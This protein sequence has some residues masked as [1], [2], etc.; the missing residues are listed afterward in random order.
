MG[1]LQS[2]NC[3]HSP[4]YSS[5][6]SSGIQYKEI[7]KTAVDIYDILL[8]KLGHSIRQGQFCTA[9]SPAAKNDEQKQNFIAYYMEYRTANK[10]LILCMSFGSSLAVF[11]NHD[12][13]QSISI[14]TW[15]IPQLKVWSWKNGKYSKRVE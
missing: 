15:R 6:F 5:A 4:N 14:G 7:W 3:I 10:N 2:W 12:I 9:F 11:T 8:T 1:L 13:L